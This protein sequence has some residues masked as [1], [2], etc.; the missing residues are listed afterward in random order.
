MADNL[1]QAK[2]GK[3]N[4]SDNKKEPETGWTDKLGR[5]RANNNIY[6]IEDID[7]STCGCSNGI[8]TC[9]I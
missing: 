5:T 1:H 8:Y 2:G 9:F 6:Q 4:T 3:V 7:G